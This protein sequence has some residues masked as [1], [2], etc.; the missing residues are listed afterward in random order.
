MR[1]L[2]KKYRPKDCLHNFLIGIKKNYKFFF[3]KDNTLSTSDI[4]TI[5]RYKKKNK[6]TKIQQLSS[7]KLN[8]VLFDYQKRKKKKI[9]INLLK[10]DVEGSEF[11]ILKSLDLKKYCPDLIQIELKNLN[12]NNL[13]NKINSYLFQKNYRLVCKTLLDSFYVYKYSKKINFLPINLYR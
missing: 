9:K 8:D 2:Y 13:K 7:R 6:I 10:I 4:K 5:K 1:P 12:L 3:F 11:E